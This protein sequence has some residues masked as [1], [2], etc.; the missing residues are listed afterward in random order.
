VE[1]YLGDGATAARDH[2]RAAGERLDHDEAERLG[3][4]DGKHEGE[5]LPQ[6]IRLGVLADLSDEF[7]EGV[8]EERLDIPVKVDL[9]DGIH[10]GGHLELD[11]DSLG[12]SDGE[13]WPLLRR[14]PPEK[15][16]VTSASGRERILGER[17]AMV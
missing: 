12:K 16:Q 1:D 13:I 8:V 17:Q 6:E 3:P 2:R 15:G 9:I 4:V 14:Y 10:L 11:A 5:S 7:D